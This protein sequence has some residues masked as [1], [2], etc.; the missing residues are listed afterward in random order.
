MVFVCGRCF[1]RAGRRPASSS[2]F[3]G[4]ARGEGGLRDVLDDSNVYRCSS[5][6]AVYYVCICHPG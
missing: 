3:E 5:T 1:E 2:L 4:P 6:C